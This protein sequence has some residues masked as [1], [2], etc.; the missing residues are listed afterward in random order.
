MSLFRKRFNRNHQKKYLFLFLLQVS[1]YIIL[2]YQ[3]PQM[4]FEHL[5]FLIVG[6]F[7]LGLV[8]FIIERSGPRS[9]TRLDSIESTMDFAE[10]TLPYFQEG[11]NSESAMIVAEII[12]NISNIPA[13]AITDRKNV[14]A[15]IGEGC[16]KHPV[17]GPIRTQATLDAI[18]DGKMHIIGNKAEFNC[19]LENCECPLESAIIVPLFN[20]EDVIG[21]LKFYD[22]NKGEMSESKIKLAVGIGKMLSMQVELADYDRQYHLST[23]AKLDALQAQVNPHFLFNSL[24]TIN[25]YINKEPQYARQ[26]IIRLSTLLRYLLGTYGRFIPLAEELSYLEDYV[27]IEN[28]RYLD[29]L[30]VDFNIDVNIDD[31]EIPV[32][33]I[34]PLVHNAIIHGIL[35]KDGV[36]RV[37]INISRLKN[38][39]IISV[40]DDGVGIKEVNM[41]KVFESG[42]GSGCGIG[43]NNVDERL[44]IL[45]GKEYGLKIQSRYMKGTIVSFRIP[46]A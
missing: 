41:K 31:I 38:E 14:L 28:A 16:D 26:L 42:N 32:F 46:I 5:L 35:P 18:A 45:Y 25:M 17:G 3:F 44:K 36:G 9:K 29:K 15:F 23:E 10:K 34:Q 21:C 4:W 40:E 20:K 6:L 11:L 24:N 7:S 37:T 39:L 27:V 1:L 2:V 22:I 13:V 43:V 12:K 33:T 19:K 30:S 8:P